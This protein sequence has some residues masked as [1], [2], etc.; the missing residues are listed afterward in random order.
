MT[1]TSNLVFRSISLISF[2]IGHINLMIT[3]ILEKQSVTYHPRVTVT[4]TL[5]SDLVNIIGIES[6]AHLL[7]SLR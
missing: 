7:F 2:K 5:T 1:L 3:C 4:L 6:G